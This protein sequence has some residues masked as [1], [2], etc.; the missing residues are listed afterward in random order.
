MHSSRA[1]LLSFN[2]RVSVSVVS[3]PYCCRMSACGEQSAAAGA[4]CDDGPLLPSRAEQ[5]HG[6]SRRIPHEH[7]RSRGT[8]PAHKG[9]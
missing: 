9:G 1:H 8:G 6:L 7:S 2:T 3:V 4:A 5:A